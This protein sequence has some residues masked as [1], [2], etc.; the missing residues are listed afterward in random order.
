MTTRWCTSFA[1][2]RSGVPLT[3]DGSHGWNMMDKTC[4]VHG[5]HTHRLDWRLQLQTRPCQPTR[6]SETR[7]KPGTPLTFHPSALRTPKPIATTSHRFPSTTNRAPPTH[8]SVS[9]TETC[10]HGNG[11]DNNIRARTTTA[12]F[13]S[14]FIY[15]E[16]HAKERRPSS[17]VAAHKLKAEYTHPHTRVWATGL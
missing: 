1:T 9:Q 16:I 13:V 10:P 17:R 11:P 8:R 6:Q 3:S 2:P 7:D 12:S 5:D 4:S 15:Q 14:T